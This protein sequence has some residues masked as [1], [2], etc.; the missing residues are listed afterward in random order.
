MQY[1]I[2]WFDFK[3]D[4]DKFFDAKNAMFDQA[5]VPPT[6]KEQM[7]DVMRYFIHENP[8]HLEAYDVSLVYNNGGIQILS[9]PNKKPRVRT[10]RP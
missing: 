8:E 1:P 6:A 5:E 3:G 9:V 7:L 10:R 2:D 4:I